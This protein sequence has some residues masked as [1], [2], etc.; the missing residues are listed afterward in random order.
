ME[1][2]IIVPEYIKSLQNQKLNDLKRIFIGIFCV[3]GYSAKHLSDKHFRK[4]K[5]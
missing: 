4:T 5:L 1:C 3:Q 2:R